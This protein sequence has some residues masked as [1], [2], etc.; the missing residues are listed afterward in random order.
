[1]SREAPSSQTEE[2]D[3]DL[4]SWDGL[5][6]I[7]VT[8]YLAAKDF[9]IDSGPQWAAAVAYYTLLSLFPLLLAVVSVAAFFVDPQWAVDQITSLLGQALPQ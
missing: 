4:M 5:R 9:F 3:V 6:R 8:F 2:R 7:G 1:M